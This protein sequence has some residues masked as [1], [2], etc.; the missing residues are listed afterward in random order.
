MAGS[1]AEGALF[2]WAPHPRARFEAMMK[3]FGDSAPRPV[4]VLGPPSLS[5][6][7]HSRPYLNELNA[8]H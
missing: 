6:A 2:A 7:E 1:V 5:G 8:T 3:F 4:F